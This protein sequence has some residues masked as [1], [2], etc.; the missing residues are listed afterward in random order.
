ML[1][2]KGVNEMDMA[3]FKHLLFNKKPVAFVRTKCDSE[4]VG[5]KDKFES[6]VNLIFLPTEIIATTS[7]SRSRD[8]FRPSF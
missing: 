5:I 6:Q 1:G 4:I 2:E 7:E 3:L 8:D